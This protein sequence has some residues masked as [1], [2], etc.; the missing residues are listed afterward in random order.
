MTDSGHSSDVLVIGGGPAGST[1][2]AFLA[3]K[4][5]SVTLLDKVCHPRFHIGES[6]LPM[7]LP[8]LERLGLAD[9][10][11]AASIYKYGA[12]FNVD[13]AGAKPQTFYFARALGD[14][15]PHAYEVRRS[16]FDNLLLRNAEGK[17]V[18]VLEG[19]RVTE[20][21]CGPAR[22]TARSVSEGG[23]ET[24]WT[25][26][27]L[28]DASG[29]DTFL[30]R[31]A[32]LKQKNPRHNSAAIFGHYENVIRRS[33]RDEGNISIYW[34]KHGWFWMIPL[35][36]GAMSVGAVCFPEYL[37]SRRSSPE[38]F[39]WDT[40]AL[41]PGVRDR[42]R[43]AKPAGPVQATGNYSY[44]SD[45]M[46]G[47]GYLLVGDAFAFVDPVFSSGV[48]LAMTGAEKAAAALDACLRDP[49]RWDHQLASLQRQVRRGI[50]TFSWFIYRFN[51]PAM[52]S[53]FMSPRNVLGM[54]RAII[55]LLAGDI[56]RR[57][58]LSLPIILFQGIYYLTCVA[59]AFQSWG[60]YQRR[61]QN[62]RLIFTGGT[63]PQDRDA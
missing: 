49:S 29:R 37:K 42:M 2:S 6:L 36:D 41:C 27:F 33:G 59:N 51:T 38:E 11:E 9:E 50:R 58:P 18:K 16:E 4:G 22:Q 13:R 10:I 7:N 57:T 60:A 12:E 21:A 30:G 35:K 5:W 47:E 24:I 17:G 63:T 48:Y 55:S 19:E 3:M 20:V 8:I 62:G 46:Y 45:R 32:G 34:F 15:P 53:L 28:V 39:L 52:R 14:S 40:I 23:E 56:F 31:N 25:S 43:H 54:E 44:T 61:R 26:R 1:V